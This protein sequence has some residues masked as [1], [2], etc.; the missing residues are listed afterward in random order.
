[1]RSTICILALLALAQ[2]EVFRREYV[3]PA[4]LPAVG[5]YDDEG[6][7]M[8]GVLLGEEDTYEQVVIRQR[9]GILQSSCSA[10][11][12]DHDISVLGIKSDLISAA[13]NMLGCSP[14]DVHFSSSVQTKYGKETCLFTSKPSLSNLD[15]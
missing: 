1:M 9:N 14:D 4:Q 5:V 12:V 13:D 11:A 10:I 6:N 8:Y 2:A 3:G 15:P 7:S